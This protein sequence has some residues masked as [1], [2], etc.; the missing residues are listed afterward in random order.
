MT[1]IL[2]RAPP[3]V[4]AIA[5]VPFCVPL[6]AQAHE[7]EAAY[8]YQRD[9]ETH[10]SPGEVRIVEGTKATLVTTQGAAFASVATRELTPGNAYTLWWVVINEPTACE[11]SPCKPPDVLQRSDI[12]RADVGYADGL[13]A[14]DDGSGRFASHLPVG[15][16]SQGWFGHG[17]DNPQG[18]EIHLVI[19]DHGPLLPEMAESMLGSARGGCVDQSFPADFPEAAFADGTPGPNT[20]R[21]VQAVIITQDAEQIAKAQ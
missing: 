17:F 6:T 20:C 18:A 12:T 2:F 3:V 4:A 14:G 5:A 21:F 9:V 16:L 7:T 11:T 13:I 10:P 19:N 8:V 1:E 15:P